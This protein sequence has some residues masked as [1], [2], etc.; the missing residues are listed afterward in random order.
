MSKNAQPWHKKAEPRLELVHWAPKPAFV[1]TVQ[2]CLSK[3]GLMTGLG[4]EPVGLPGQPPLISF[5]ESH[6]VPL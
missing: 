3:S 4:R 6:N 1:T 2:K 5:H